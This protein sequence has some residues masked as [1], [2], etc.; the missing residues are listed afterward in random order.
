MKKMI[1]L[2]ILALVMISGCNSVAS[3]LGADVV[4]DNIKESDQ[5]RHKYTLQYIDATLPL[6]DENMQEADKKK[7]KKIGESLKRISTKEN[8][9]LQGTWDK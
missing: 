3:F 4:T 8:Q 9:L 1:L 5:I 6:V 2:A 7:F